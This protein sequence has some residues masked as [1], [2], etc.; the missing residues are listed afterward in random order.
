MDAV[1]QHSVFV[2]RVTLQC[3]GVISWALSRG[4]VMLHRAWEFLLISFSSAPQMKADHLVAPNL[5]NKWRTEWCGSAVG[6]AGMALPCSASFLSSEFI[7]CPAWCPQPPPGQ[8]CPAP[9]QPQVVCRGASERK[10]DCLFM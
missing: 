3:R 6:R 10:G 5:Q 4:S 9:K 7:P 2:G 1:S 8:G